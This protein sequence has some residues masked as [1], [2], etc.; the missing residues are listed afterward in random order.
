MLEEICAT[1]HRFGEQAHLQ[2]GFAVP[3]LLLVAPDLVAEAIVLP[4]GR[5]GAEGHAV[6]RERAQAI[7]AVAAALTSESWLG[8]VSVPPSGFENLAPDDLPRA[9]DLP[10]R[11]EAIATSAV[12][13]VGGAM[14][15]RV[16]RIERTPGGSVLGPAERIGAR[17]YG[18]TRWLESLI[19]PP[20]ATGP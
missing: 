20:P 7:G 3:Q 5:P 16:T 12:W 10:D 19:S 15:H 2:V 17:D 8:F 4:G 18:A 6:L 9:V 13:P 11:M 1:L 14:V